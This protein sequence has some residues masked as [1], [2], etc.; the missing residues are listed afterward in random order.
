MR[1]RPDIE[2][3]LLPVSKLHE[4][5]CC[6]LAP[7]G[8]W[9]SS[10]ACSQPNLIRSELFE[11]SQQF[12]LGR[13]AVMQANKA[14]AVRLNS[15]LKSAIDDAVQ[16][17]DP[18]LKQMLDDANK[19]WG[20]EVKGTF[21]SKFIKKIANSQPEDLL[22]AIIVS[23]K[24]GDIRMI[25]EIVEKGDPSGK[26]WF[27]VQGAFIQR[28]LFNSSEARFISSELGERKFVPSGK[29]L[30]DNLNRLMDVDGANMK[31]LFPDVASKGGTAMRNIQRYAQALEN[32]ERAIGGSGGGSVWLQLGQASVVSGVIGAGAIGIYTGHNTLGASAVGGAAVFLL[33]PHAMARF[34]VS[35]QA[36]RW[37]IIGAEHAPGTERAMKATVSLLGI[38]IRENLLEGSQAEAASAHIQTLNQELAAG[39]VVKE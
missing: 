4:K 28:L 8:A 37:L 11:L 16:T 30:K 2:E 17:A 1:T 35:K 29:K 3:K 32:T 25:R 13:T 12:E 24:P 23:G 38:M 19:I 18:A 26:A 7:T 9:H 5:T 36:S 14:A 10:A 34:W 6:R 15:P 21:T 31:Q 22:D 20:E 33:A 39:N 27:N